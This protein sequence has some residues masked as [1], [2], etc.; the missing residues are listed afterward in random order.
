MFKF[1][2]N[3]L[4]EAC[5]K[6]KRPSRSQAVELDIQGEQSARVELAPAFKINVQRLKFSLS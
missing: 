2:Y 6:L 5:E 4:E 3:L 1:L